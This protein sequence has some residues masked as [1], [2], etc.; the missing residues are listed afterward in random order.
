MQ[1]C[2]PQLKASDFEVWNLLDAENFLDKTNKDM[3]VLLEAC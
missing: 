3:I 2:D 1:I